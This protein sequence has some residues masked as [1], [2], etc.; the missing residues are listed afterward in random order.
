MLPWLV[1]RGL[2]FGFSFVPAQTFAMQRIT[3]PALPKASS[4]LNMLRQIA[5]SVGTALVITTFVQRTSFH[6]SALG[7]TNAVLA[8]NLAVTD[9]FWLVT[10]GALMVLFV[11]LALPN[12]RGKEALGGVA[13]TAE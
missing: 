11:G 2:G 12:R 13:V 3:G 1:L 4:L 8:G 9:V 10:I 6:T 7:P 5:G